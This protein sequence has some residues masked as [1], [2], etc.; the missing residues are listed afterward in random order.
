MTSDPAPEYNPIW[1]PDGRWIGFVRDFSDGKRGLMLIPALGGSEQKLVDMSF[2]FEGWELLMGVRTALSWSP[3]S[4]WIAYIDTATSGE[5]SALFAVSIESGE[6]KRLTKPADPYL[7]DYSPAISPDGR[8]IAF[9]R[10]VGP[11]TGDIYIRSLLS[12]M[13]PGDE[14]KLTM[15]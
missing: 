13:T 6:K 11:T 12:D 9:S 10:A 5:A 3:D 2:R 14:R 1:S 7:I 4:R 15:D 8:A